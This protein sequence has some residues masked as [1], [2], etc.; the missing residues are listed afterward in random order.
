MQEE[1]AQRMYLDESMY[2]DESGKKMHYCNFYVDDK[3]YYAPPGE[4]FGQALG[5]AI[6]FPYFVGAIATTGLLSIIFGSIA[7]GIRYGG[8]DKKTTGGVIALVIFFFLCLASMTYS[9]ISMKMNLDELKEGE[10]P[11]YSTK[12]NKILFLK[13]VQV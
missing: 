12:E 9:I 6:F 1:T 2:T 13:K 3:E 10:R 8:K 4:K 7:L 11:C 5:T